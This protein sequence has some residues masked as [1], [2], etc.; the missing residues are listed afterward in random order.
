MVFVA[1]YAGV[2]W[3]LTVITAGVLR[4]RQLEIA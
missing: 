2:F 1:L 3:T 4:G